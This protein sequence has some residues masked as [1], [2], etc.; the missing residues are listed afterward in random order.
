MLIKQEILH[1]VQ[2]VIDSLGLTLYHIEFNRA[3]LRIMVEANDNSV[4]IETCANV[5][6]I[7]STKLDSDNLINY[8]YYLEVSSPGIERG[9]Y[10][11]EHYKRF[12]G[13]TCRLS[14]KFGSFFGKI[15]DA[16]EMKLKVMPLEKS[17]FL[18][19]L[20]YDEMN[21]YFIIPFTEIKSGQLKVTDE[22]LFAKKH[23]WQ[24]VTKEKQ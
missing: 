13:E 6:K 8:R 7:L 22:N 9:L 4:T 18:T 10:E 11:P 24:E 21:N 1:I 5:A 16:D 17:T 12:V 15:V 3:V 20:N 23:R 14:T 2:S 19:G